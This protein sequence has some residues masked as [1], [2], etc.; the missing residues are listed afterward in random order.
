MK[1]TIM[2]L[3]NLLTF[4]VV[5]VQVTSRNVAPGDEQLQQCGLLRAAGAA[6]VPTYS[7]NM[8]V[9]MNSWNYQNLL[10]PR[11]G[12]V[13][14]QVDNDN[15]NPVGITSTV[16]DILDIVDSV[17]IFQY[18]RYPQFMPLYLCSGF[19]IQTLPV[20]NL[21]MCVGSV[22]VHRVTG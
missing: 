8:R 1:S 20:I 15:N 17:Y 16:S 13:W 18:K 19:R 4:Y 3:I 5:T 21:S 12:A 2:L 22:L 9:L 6:P 10:P 11:T 7:A 14:D